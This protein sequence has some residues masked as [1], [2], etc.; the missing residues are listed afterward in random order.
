MSSLSGFV[1]YQPGEH[2]R[3]AEL[4]AQN[5]QGMR[6]AQAERHPHSQQLRL[7]AD[8]EAKDR[9]EAQATSAEQASGGGR[10]RT[11]LPGRGST[12]ATGK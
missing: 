12:W 6:A 5:L 8:Q 7:E 3:I 2:R 4:V 1:P 9:A 10:D 11:A